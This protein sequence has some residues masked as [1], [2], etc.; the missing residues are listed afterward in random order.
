MPG[1]G[2]FWGLCLPCLTATA[3]QAAMH[4]EPGSI[5]SL[6]FS[7]SFFPSSCFLDSWSLPALSLF[8]SSP[9]LL[10]LHP[11]YLL[12]LLPLL[13]LPPANPFSFSASDAVPSAAPTCSPSVIFG[14]FRQG[15]SFATQSGFKLGSC[16][17]LPTAGVMDRHHPAYIS[18]FISSVSGP[19]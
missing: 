2:R 6:E 14:V 7:E 15:F 13:L 3:P 1:V 12:P 10:C 16:L 11:I 18:I 9:L 8:L 17:S 19:V 5:L 4:P